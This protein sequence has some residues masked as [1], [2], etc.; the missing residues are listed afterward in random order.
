MSK[1]L[2]GAAKVCINPTP[3]MYPIPT[4]HK[5]WG[6]ASSAQQC[7]YD[8][9]HVRAI[10]I[11][12]GTD[13]LMFVVYELSGPPAVEGLAELIG[14]ATGF[15]AE[16]IIIAATHNHTGCKDV[17]FGPTAHLVTPEELA[18]FEAYKKIETERGIEAAKKAVASMRSARYGYGE[19][20]SY[21]NTNRD[22]KTMFGY[23]VEGRNLAGYSDKTLA[24]VKFVDEEGK[25][26]AALMNH[27]THAT[28]CYMMRD[29]DGKA[30]TSGNFNG[31]TSRFVEEHYGNGAVA[32][33]TSGAAGNQNPLLSH[34]MQYEYPDG[35]T[36]A[37]QY[38]D[39][40]GYMQMEFMGRY[41]GADCVKGI[42]AISEYSEIMPIRHVRRSTW[43]P[44]QQKIL[45]PGM[46]FPV[47]MGG[48]FPRT[49]ESA[50]VMPELPERVPDP[51]H[52]TELR[53]QLV[54]MGDI[55]IVGVGGEPY[56][57]L[58]RDIKAA[59]P[60]K[61]T[62][63]VTHITGGMGDNPHAVG[64]IVDKSSI[65]S[66]NVKMYRNLKPGFY[67]ELIIEAAKELYRKAVEA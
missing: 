4:S 24:I 57:E 56:A 47:R 36:A 10:A 50:P 44:T 39:G 13:R 33:W 49:D 58:G 63:V 41:H 22:L 12:N 51:E 23:W 55:A 43:L 62:I 34:G 48:S 60:A 35:Y 29:A 42:D 3:D 14:E 19:S 28:C 6:A 31:I 9:M 61:H 18:F 40:V 38:P 7:A 65:G 11:D 45:K 8:D 59:L 54:T 17:P 21:I 66:H 27:G 32:V 53:M 15:P 67:D 5:D 20:E 2:V 25:L 16:N 46:V 1:L 64:Y 30:K 52:P 26:I 37:V